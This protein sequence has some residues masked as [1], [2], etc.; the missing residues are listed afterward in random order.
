MEPSVS[1]GCAKDCATND[2]VQTKSSAR[3]NNGKVRSNESKMVTT[4]P[5]KASITD[6]STEEVLILASSEDKVWS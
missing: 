3:N 2:V 1:Q 5:C 6:I 4:S